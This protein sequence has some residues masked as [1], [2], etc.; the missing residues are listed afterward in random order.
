MTTPILPKP[1]TA[2]PGFER[3]LVALIPHLRTFSRAICGPREIA[4]DMAQE[5]L[6]KAWAARD[7]FAPGTNL[8]AW[9]FTILRN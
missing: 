7:S 9:L 6:L 8:K 1:A 2:V 4:H 3:D 5:S